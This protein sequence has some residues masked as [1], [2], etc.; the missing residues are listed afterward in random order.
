MKVHNAHR[1]GAINNGGP[2]YGASL[3]R[4]KCHISTML[5]A[6]PARIQII[7]AGQNEPCILSIGSQ[8][9]KK[10]AETAIKPAF[11]N[12]GMGIIRSSSARKLNSSNLRK[13]I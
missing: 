13:D 3:Y 4:T 9:V 10:T 12:P 2:R 5:A 8:A 7:Q 6:S 1:L 11:R